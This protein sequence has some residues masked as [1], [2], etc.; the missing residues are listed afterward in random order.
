MCA[1][2]LHGN[3]G[4]LPKVGFKWDSIFEEETKTGNFSFTLSPMFLYCYIYIV[5]YIYIYNSVV[6]FFYD[7]LFLGTLMLLILNEENAF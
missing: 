7:N 3:S 5:I 4:P 2:S 1:M 6:I